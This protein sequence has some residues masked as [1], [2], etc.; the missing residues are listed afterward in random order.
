MALN[1]IFKLPRF[2]LQGTNWPRLKLPQYLVVGSDGKTGIY[3]PISRY[4]FGNNLEGNFAR[5]IKIY[6]YMY[7]LTYGNLSYRHI[8]EVHKD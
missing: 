2:Y 3:T 6:K 4:T 7:L 1:R 5:S 8:T